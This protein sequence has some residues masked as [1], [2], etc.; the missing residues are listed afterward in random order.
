[1]P[2]TRRNVYEMIYHKLDKLTGGIEKFTASNNYIKLKSS[3]FMDLVIECNTKNYISM[4]HYYKQGGDLI[5]D[6][7][8]EIKIIPDLKMAEAMTFQDFLGFQNVYTEDGKKYYP[9]RKK[10]LNSFLNKWLS[11][12]QIQGFYK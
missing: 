4:T 1:M 10:S 2:K 8:M 9:A 11:N 12:L 5:P 6:P 3:G 7:D